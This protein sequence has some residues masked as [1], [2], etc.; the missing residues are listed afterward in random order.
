M[1]KILVTGSEGFLGRYLVRALLQSG[2][3]VV[4]FDLTLSQN[5]RGNQERYEHFCGDVR[6]VGSVLDAIAEC[7]AVF[8]LAGIA[9]LDA[10][11]ADPLQAADINVVG[12]ASVLE[13]CRRAG[14]GRFI[15]ASTVYVHSQFGSV[16]RTT[17]R[18]A[19]SL[20]WDCSQLWGFR[21][22]IL[23]V[24]SLYGPGADNNNAIRRVINMGLREGHI[25][26]WGDGSEIREYIHAADAARLATLVLDERF[27]SRSIHLAGRDRL[28]TREIVGMIAEIIGGDT[29][30]SFNE[31]PYSGRYHLTPY[32]L[33]STRTLLGERLTDETHIDIGLGLLETIET[34][35]VE[36]ENE[37]EPLA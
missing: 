10:A 11:A 28:A 17:K 16:Y 19:E 36:L 2:H 25:E 31:E 23:R 12:T 32:S 6:D 30:V 1:T 8:H 13:A 5:Q 4:G 15:F 14:V 33:D 7:E 18:A 3:D 9:D 20:I 21:S 35:S 24:G 29:Q 37:R 34:I 26:F 22:T 27:A